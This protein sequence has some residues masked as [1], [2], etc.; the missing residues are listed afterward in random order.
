M[1]RHTLSVLVEDKPGVLAQLTSLLS[2]A[3]I[4]IHNLSIQ[5]AR[6]FEGGQVRLFISSPTEAARA[7]ELLRE[8]GYDCE[9]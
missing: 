1:S 3:R 2:E 7:R 8:A 9:N 5:D 4:N 6:Q